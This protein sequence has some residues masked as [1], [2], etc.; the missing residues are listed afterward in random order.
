MTVLAFDVYGTLIDPLGIEAALVPA[1]GSNARAACELWRQKQLEYSFRRALMRRY[2]T[3][4]ACTAQALQFTAARFGARPDAGELLARY[5]NL[6]AYPDVASALGRLPAKRVAFSNGTAS[7][8]RELLGS[9]GLIE[10]FAEVISV[11]DVQSFK[12]DPAVYEH[13]VQRVGEPKESVWMISSNPFDVIGAKCGGLRAAW[14]KRNANTV[15]D[16]WDIEPDRI[17]TSLTEL[18]DL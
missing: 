15:F 10:Q 3:F 11:D 16:P 14:L 13:L 8:V 4:D 17:V 2:M 6:P 12:P 9:A 1:F 7:S 18:E 5:R